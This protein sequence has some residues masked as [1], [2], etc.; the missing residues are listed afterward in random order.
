MAGYRLYLVRHAVAEDRGEAWPDDTKRPLTDSGAS[1]WRRSVRGLV[2][3]GVSLDVIL[4]SPLVRARQTSD[5]LASAFEPRPPIV[6]VE[7][8]APGGPY[9]TV[10]A[11]IGKQSRRAGMAI[12]GHEP[13]IGETAAH[14]AGLRHRLEFKKGAVC[15]IDVEALTPQAIGRLR[16]F[17][18]PRI[19][20]A[21][22]R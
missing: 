15:R 18:T 14:L 2:R 19:M 22:K 21:L 11:E 13:D 5:I 4:T 6:V 3:L 9:P 1:R 12:V 17:L 20:R 16:W 10:L 8:L 7:S